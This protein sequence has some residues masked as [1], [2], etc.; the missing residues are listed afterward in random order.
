MRQLANAISR[1]NKLFDFSPAQLRVLAVL[2][3]TAMAM[4]TYLLLRTYGR[5]AGAQNPLPVV[6]GPVERKLSGVFVV[7]LNTSPGDSLEL[8]PGVGGTLANRIV[9]HRQLKRFEKA[10][11]VTEVK[12]I[13]PKLYESIKPYVKV[14]R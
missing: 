12:G 10:I 11:D 7:D 14:S 2:A 4:S 3:L 13:G 9:E 1:V 5:P 8:L 6:L